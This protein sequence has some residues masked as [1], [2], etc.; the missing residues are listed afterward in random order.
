MRCVVVTIR[1][2][3]LLVVGLIAVV[4]LVANAGAI[5]GWLWEIGLIPWAQ[6]VRREYVTGTAMTVIVVLLV[7]LPSR[8]VW[9]IYVRRCPVCDYLL[10]RRGKY[11]CECG[12][13]V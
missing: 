4:L 3:K 7:L 8:K 2:R 1:N 13:R 11:C 6:Y 9:E 10:L 5:A 12:S